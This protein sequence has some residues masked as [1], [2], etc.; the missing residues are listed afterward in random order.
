LSSGKRRLLVILGPTGAGKSAVAEEVARRACGEIISA[1]AFAVYRGLDIGTAKPPRERRA[2]IPYHLLDVAE[3]GESFS[4]G[5][6]AALAERAAEDISGRRRLPIVCGGSGFYIRALLDG[7]PAG[8]AKDPR[9]RLRL[10]AWAERDAAASRRFLEVNDPV[11]SAR[12]A[13]GNWRSILRAIEILLVTGRPA[14][15]RRYP[16]PRFRDRWRVITVGIAPSRPEL[17][18]KIEHRVREMLNAGW[19]EEVRRLL[20]SGLSIDS[21]SFQA[22]GYREVADW[23]M[24]QAVKE[25]AEGKIVTATR[26]LAKRQRTWFARERGVS[27][28]K[29]EEAIPAILALLEEESE[30]EKSG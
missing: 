10:K 8:E 27:W 24:G 7:L 12:I 9:L 3:P 22:I 18:A 4:A 6:W 30:T 1:D 19:L 23:A 25:A 26:R 29:P 16:T 5:R 15:Q 20:E 13:P 17:Y 11:S 14:S 28:V 21:P 2:E